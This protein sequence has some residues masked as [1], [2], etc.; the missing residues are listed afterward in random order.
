MRAAVITRP[1]GPEV[2]AVREVTRPEPGPEQVLVRVRASALNRS[3]LF[4]RQGLYPAPP[5][6]NEQ[7]PGIEFAGEVAALG[8]GVQ[9]WREGERVFGII[10]GGGQAEYVVV[11]ERAVAA[12]PEELSWAEAGGVP[13]AFITAHDAL[14]TQAA[15]RPNERVLVHAAG[16]GVGL[17]MLQLARTLGAVPYGTARSAWKL[18][19]ARDYGMEDGFVPPA[20]LAGLRERVD[21]WTDGRGVDVVLD[22]VGGPYV[23]ASANA[24]A[25]KGRLL[26]IGSVGG[27]DAR[28]PLGRVMY[29]RVTIKGTVLRARPIEERILATRAF[30]A[31][32][33]PFLRAGVLR[34]A[35][36]SRFPLEQIAA[37]HERLASNETFGKVVVEIAP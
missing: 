37:A 23:E 16:S 17:A 36:D 31:E 6:A 32:V 1:G 21:A 22:L 18:D 30:A 11:H 3:D 27:A 7:V 26:L 8:P 34:P 20:D 19:R 5:G 28:L 4:Q 35:I 2:L 24:L 14:V 12:A 25:L 33:V 29:Q 13:E 9:L 15:L 10:G